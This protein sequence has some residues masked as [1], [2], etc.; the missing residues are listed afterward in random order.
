MAATV[1]LRD[2]AVQ[3]Q[4]FAA[5]KREGIWGEVREEIGSG[6]TQQGGIVDEVEGPLG[7]E[8]RAQVPVQLPDGTGGFQVVRFIGVDGPGG[9]CAGSSR[10]R[11][12][13][14]RRRPGCS[15]R[16]SGTPSWSAAR[17]RWRLATR[18]S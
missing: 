12:R 13:C 6:I 10:V 16:S 3:L 4:G 11:A 14:S 15:S 17:A 9:S 18:S 8:L 7:W 1:V 2:S 5:P